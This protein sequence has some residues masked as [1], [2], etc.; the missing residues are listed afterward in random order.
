MSRLFVL[1]FLRLCRVNM[2]PSCSCGLSTG[3]PAASH[4][5]PTPRPGKFWLYLISGAGTEFGG[6]VTQDRD[7][8]GVSG[9]LMPWYLRVGIWTRSYACCLKLLLLERCSTQSSGFS[10]SPL[11]SRISYLPRCL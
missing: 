9:L 3:G 5:S 8:T 4:L 7:G 11:S 6:G 1:T 10:V 2:S